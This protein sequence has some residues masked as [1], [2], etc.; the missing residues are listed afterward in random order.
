MRRDA[1]EN[2]KSAMTHFSENEGASPALQ[3]LRDM[4]VV[5]AGGKP[6]SL[7]SIEA[8]GAEPGAWIRMAEG[9]QVR[10]P[11]SLLRPQDDGVCRLPFALQ[12]ETAAQLR[13][14]V[15]EE[16][17]Q[18]TTRK[19]D[20]GSG[21]RIHKTVTEREQL[22]DPPLLEDELE[23]ERVPVGRVVTESEVP[24]SHY[25]GDTLVLPVLEEV[26]VVQKQL[27]VKEELR[28]TRQRR[29]VHK[30]QTVSLRAEQIRVERFDR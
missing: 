20:T 28:I 21:V 25:E 23:V 15:M 29:E 2:G 4:R 3:R 18:V 19:V 22:L 1:L 11:L 9:M 27:L 16:E 6:A 8:E 17:L 12:G 13:F 30:P 14:P 10:V 7:V 5:D 24:Q 26:L